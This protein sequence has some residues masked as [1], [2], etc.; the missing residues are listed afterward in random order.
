MQI[1]YHAPYRSVNG[2]VLAKMQEI[3]VKLALF[4]F[5]YEIYG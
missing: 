3:N 4:L 5:D 1:F 2:I